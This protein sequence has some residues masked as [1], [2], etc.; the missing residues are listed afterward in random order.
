[1]YEM[2]LF[3]L[4]LLYFPQFEFKKEKEPRK[5]AKNEHYTVVNQIILSCFEHRFKANESENKE[6]FQELVYAKRS[7]FRFKLE[8]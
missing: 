5:D 1:M 2:S 7:R 6:A 4:N 3:L 8:P